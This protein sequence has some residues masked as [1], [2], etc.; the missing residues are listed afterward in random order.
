M[1]TKEELRNL[2]GAFHRAEYRINNSYDWNF[3]CSKSL[4]FFEFEAQMKV[5]DI[6]IKDNPDQCKISHIIAQGPSN[7][8]MEFETQNGKMQG[9]VSPKIQKY[10]ILGA[11]LNTTPMVSLIHTKGMLRLE[12]SYEYEWMLHTAD[13]LIQSK[14]KLG[15]LVALL[16]LD[17]FKKPLLALWEKQHYGSISDFIEEIEQSRGWHLDIYSKALIDQIIACWKDGAI[18][19]LFA[20]DNTEW[21]N[22]KTLEAYQDIKHIRQTEYWNKELPDIDDIDEEDDWF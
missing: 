13:E 21:I 3:L 14:N 11:V 20:N 10:G 9:L 6:K 16:L 1:L 18:E 2:I 12:P 4:T 15:S 17:F 5:S 19:L 7:K 22:E 8:Y